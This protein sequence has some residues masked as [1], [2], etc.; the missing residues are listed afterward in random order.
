MCYSF[1]TF[2]LTRHQRMPGTQMCSFHECTFYF[3]ILFFDDLKKHSS[4]S[5]KK[6][7]IYKR[8]CYLSSDFHSWLS[9]GASLN[10]LLL[11]QK[12]KSDEPDFSR[13]LCNDQTSSYYLYG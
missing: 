13:L 8:F 11:R 12:E 10:Q 9:L 3:V 1:F 7:S 5:P 4:S 6:A 2:I